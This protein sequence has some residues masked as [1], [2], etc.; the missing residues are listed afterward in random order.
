VSNLLF[1]HM[2]VV[3]NI[4]GKRVKQAR[5]MNGWSLAKL[6][7][8]MGDLVSVAALSKY[9]KG[10]SMASSK[11]LISLSNA[12]NVSIDY[13]FR[14]FEVELERIRFRKMS[15]LPKREQG[16]VT[17][18]A[19]DFFERYFEIE[20]ICGA[21]IPF[22]SPLENNSSLDCEDMADKLRKEWDIGQNPISNVHALLEEKGIKVWY[23]KDCDDKFDGFSAET[24]NG[25]VIVVNENKSAAR[26][27]MTALHELAHI[28]C[29]PLDMDE[30]VEEKFVPRFTG[31]ILLPAQSLRDILGNKRKRI[32]VGELLAIK[33][34]YGV[35]MAGV[36]ARAKDLEIITQSTYVS[37]YTYGPAKIWRS[38]KKEPSDE[39]LD[40]LFPESHY[41]FKQ[42][43]YRA[44]GEELITI[45]QAATYLKCS[46]D[47]VNNQLNPLD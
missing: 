4:F 29:K 26:L 1:N 19:R 38:T 8:E 30:K 9:E 2:A 27:R 6:R 42:L 15:T 5:I 24:A 23:A 28:L 21:V 3:E 44:Y 13:F 39:D 31:A 45:S 10:Q 12:L 25:P 46:I 17:E 33:K 41:R 40:L 43:V 22:Q 11:V 7:E 35:S 47:E 14:K 36:L 32:P 20:E 18:K 34:R 16:I 37:Y